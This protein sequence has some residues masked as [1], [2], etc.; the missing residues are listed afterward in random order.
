MILTIDIGNTKIIVARFDENAPMK[1]GCLTPVKTYR[2]PT[3]DNWN[4]NTIEV[5]LTMHWNVL[6]YGELTGCIISSVVPRL[7]Y[8]FEDAVYNVTGIHSIIVRNNMKL[9]FR[10]EMDHPEKVGCD[11]LVD[12][13]GAMTEHSGN[14]III[15]MGTAT[16]FSILR[17]EEDQSKTYSGTIIMPGLGISQKALAENCAQLPEVD[18]YKLPKNGVRLDARNT[19]ESIQSGLVYGHAAMVDGMIERIMKNQNF[20]AESTTVIA[21]GGLAPT[22]LPNCYNK[23]IILDENL[24]LKGLYYLYEKNQVVDE[25]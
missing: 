10:V 20:A 25:I 12:T 17:V 24:M 2:I 23:D 8:M 7:T 11:L 14:L 5:A 16:T 4:I 21:T 9:G 19:V 13:C 15:D 18:L 22:V 6:E 1:D 3:N